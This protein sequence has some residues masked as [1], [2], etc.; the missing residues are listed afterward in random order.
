[1]SHLCKFRHRKKVTIDVSKMLEKLAK[2]ELSGLQH[3]ENFNPDSVEVKKSNLIDEPF[4]EES[5]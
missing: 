1:M 5:L 2:F 4:S 3:F